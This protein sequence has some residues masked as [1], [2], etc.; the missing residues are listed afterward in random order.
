MAGEAMQ[1]FFN[2]V[3]KASSSRSWSRGIELARDDA[4]D[5]LEHDE[6]SVT[7]R[8]KQPGRTV[9]PVVT[10]FLEDDEWVCSCD[11]KEAVCS[12]AAA[13][14]IAVRKAR[15]SGRAL[16]QSA[17]A[18]A[19]IGYRLGTDQNRLTV[20]RVLVS[21]GG[22]TERNLRQSLGTLAG[23]GGMAVEPSEV[24]LSIDRLLQLKR[25]RIWPSEAL[26]P[27]FALLSDAEDVRYGEDAVRVRREKVGPRV[28]ILARGRNFIVRFDKPAGWVRPV[29][30]GV[31]LFKKKGKLE[32]GLL[33]MIEVTGTT[34]DALPAEVPYPPDRVAELITAVVP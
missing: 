21:P 13:A 2:A 27:L 5:G 3:R 31:G 20:A 19:R 15:Q 26:P 17:K 8:V 22:G 34:L 32:V 24:D 16:P 28:R 4:V 18:G 9:A 7:V 14:T 33:D 23:Q 10:L 25:L 6:D 12:H 30:Q 29:A 1:D 11:S